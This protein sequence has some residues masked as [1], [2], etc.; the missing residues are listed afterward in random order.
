MTKITDMSPEAERVLR[1]VYRNM[2]FARKWRQ[3]ADLLQTGKVLH[4]AGVRLRKPA[5]TDEEIRASWVAANLGKAWAEKA[6]RPAMEGQKDN[7]HV[8]LEVLAVLTRLE[9]P[10]ALGGSWASSLMGKMR[11]TNDADLIVEP[12]PGKET[13]FCAS[14]GDDYYVSLSAVQ[15]A[16]RR[17]SSFNVVHTASAFK[18]DVFVRKDRPFDASVM[19]RRRAFPLP[20]APGQVLVC[21]SPED[22]VLLK[23]EWYRLGGETSERQWSEVRGVLEIQAERLDQA[24]LDHWAKELGGADLLDRAWRESVIE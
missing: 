3:M 10:Y 1:E 2:P 24:Y 12:F 8:L 19:A 21:V 22:V 20:E 23:L 17:R 14:F 11:F 16:V 9:V 18:V 13:A 5:A 7:L 6:R 4:G 15:E